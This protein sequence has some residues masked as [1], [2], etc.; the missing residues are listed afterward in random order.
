MIRA[1][2]AHAIVM[3]DIHRASFPPA[4]AWGPDAFS[5]QLALPGVFALIDEAGG[6]LLARVTVDEAEVLT[7]AVQPPARHRGI[8]RRL[9]AA[10][11]EEAGRC[12]ALNMF[13][14]VSAINYAARNLYE[15]SCFVQVGLRRGYYPDG[16][17]ALVMR[18]RITSGAPASA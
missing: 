2:P 11:M 10:A 4:E 9:L 6:L 7:L 17:D 14:E 12:G 13:L 3:A 5:M 18:H 8:G 1:T 16:S 15:K